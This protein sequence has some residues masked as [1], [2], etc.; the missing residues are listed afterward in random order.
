[1]AD[2]HGLYSRGHLPCVWNGPPDGT[3]LLGATVS[4]GGSHTLSD[5]LCFPQETAHSAQAVSTAGK[6]HDVRLKILG[7][8]QS[9]AT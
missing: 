7:P 6:P 9:G 2:R 3:W 8:S 5:M 1:M 4:P